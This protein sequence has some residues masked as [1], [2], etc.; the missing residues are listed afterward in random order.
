MY[1]ENSHPQE[2]LQAV[3]QL[4]PQDH[5]VLMIFVGEK[6]APSLDALV[7]L[8]QEKNVDFF[9]AL[10][11]ALIYDDKKHESGFIIQ[12]FPKYISPILIQGLDQPDFDLSHLPEIDTES[13]AL[14]ALVLLD[15]M[16]SNISLFFF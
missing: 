13:E 3:E 7:E 14:S 5:E 12:K 11:P 6:D 4:A 1:L 16:T 8:L 15:G 10:F 2:L 9:G